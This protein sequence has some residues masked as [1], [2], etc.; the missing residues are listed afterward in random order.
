MNMKS[1]LRPALVALA[2]SALVWSSVM[3]PAAA[4]AFAQ[5]HTLNF[6]DAEIQAFIDD[7]S[8]VTGYTFIVDPEVRGRI[9]ITSQTPLTEAEVFQV[10]LSTLRV[11]G[12]TAV[13]TRSGAY[14]IVPEA[15]GARSGARPNNADLGEQFVTS[16]I[17]LSNA[18]AQDALRSVQPM[19]SQTGS[20]NAIRGSNALIVVDYGSNVTAIETLLGDLDRDDS[21]M[22]MVALDNVSAAEMTR[23]VERSLVNNRNSEQRS[24]NLSVV[25]VASSNSILLR[26]SRE[27]VAEMVS[28]VRRV[29]A[30]SESNQTFRVVRLE[31]TQGESLVPILEQVSRAVTQDGGEGGAVG[32][33]RQTSIGYHEATNSIIINAPADILRELELVIRQLDIRRPQVLVEAIIVEVSDTTARDLGVQFAVA[34]SGGT[35]PFAS[36]RFGPSTG[37]VRPDLLALTGAIALRNS[38]DEDDKAASKDLSASAI[39]SLLGSR[40]GLFGVGGESNGTV[41]GVLVNALEQDTDSNVLSKPHL[42]TLDN[43][44]ANLIVGQEIPITTGETL[45]SNNNN[46]FR[47]VERQDVGVQLY[48][49]P[50]INDG[51]TIRLHIRQEVSALVGPVSST[52]TDLIT[53]KREIETTAL[54]ENGEIIV[55]GGLMEQNDQL[56]DSKVPVLGDIP[57]VGRLFRNESRSTTRKNLMVFLR[58]TIVRSEED[59]RNLTRRHYDYMVGEQR[60]ATAGESSSLESVVNMMLNS[61]APIEPRAEERQP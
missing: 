22:E 49:K 45:S 26:G 31:H 58:P 17:R 41:W 33:G 37:S 21:V 24:E 42:M 6:R 13:R 2:G 20:V 25:P 40:G 29:D 32:G 48:V 14:Q 4:P 55:L 28:L 53:S 39:A 44:E 3:G 15:D 38:K 60:N 12:Y 35:V 30:V 10:F 61:T 16:V 19:V 5:E 57:A 50:Q 59:V 1:V 36:T 18:D 11:H 34:G 51:D 7:V 9:T 47:T 23:I 46:P 54:A 27:A 52:S 8:I 56:A 43:E